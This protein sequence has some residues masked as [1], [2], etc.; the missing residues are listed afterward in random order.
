M[1]R[2]WLELNNT[3]IPALVDR[4]LDGNCRV[5]FLIKSGELRPHPYRGWQ[6]KILRG[7]V[8]QEWIHTVT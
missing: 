1:K 8:P 3:Y 4:E 2:V 5:A 7:W 6:P